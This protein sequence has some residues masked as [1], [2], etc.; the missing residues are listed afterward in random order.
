MGRVPGTGVG[1]IASVDLLIILRVPEDQSSH[2]L[3]V[4]VESYLQ[5]AKARLRGTISMY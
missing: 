1:E 5:M 3:G 2:D 4:A